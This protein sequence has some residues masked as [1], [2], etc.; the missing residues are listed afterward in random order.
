MISEKYTK[1]DY[2]S[3][4]GHKFTDL[5][6]PRACAH[7]K[8]ISF[9][10]PLPCTVALIPVGLGLVVIRRGIEPHKGEFGLPGG[11]MDANE[12]WQ[13]GAAREIKEEVGITVDPND[14]SLLH[15]CSDLTNHLL[16]FCQT[17]EVS[18]RELYENFK[19][20]EE[21]LELA[22]AREPIELAFQRH[23]EAL[24]DYLMN[25][26]RRLSSVIA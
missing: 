12:T 8:N 13:K 2:C 4:C 19:V 25:L 7:C 17:R 22:I 20:N 15:V 11:Y 26:K 3:Y 21:S 24:S 14:M 9:I 1:D 10:N 16:I 23:T 5:K 6:W 18:E